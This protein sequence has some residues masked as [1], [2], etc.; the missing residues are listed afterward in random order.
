MCLTCNVRYK[1]GSVH[2]ELPNLGHILFVQVIRVYREAL[3]AG[4][5]RSTALVARAVILRPLFPER[6]QVVKQVS[7][8]VS[9][10]LGLS[11][12]IDLDLLILVILC[13]FVGLLFG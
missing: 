13:K 12:Q 1:I 9:G 5:F 11:L 10:R 3:G 2:A 8:N 4:V 7:E 6:W